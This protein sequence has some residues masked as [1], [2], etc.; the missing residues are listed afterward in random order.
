MRSPEP[1]SRDAG[2]TLVEA[3][4]VFVVLGILTAWAAPRFDVAVEQTRVDQAAAALRSIWLGQR[5]HWLEHQTFA[6]TLDELVE[7]RFLDGPMAAQTAP[8][9][10]AITDADAE[11]FG[12]TAERT[13]S[14]EWTGT[15]AIDERGA[16]TGETHG[17]GG[18]I[19]SPAQ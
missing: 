8:F 9:V 19:V 17:G 18:Q 1:H 3:M 12:A 2:F 7:E 5:M 14:T 10:L 11:A 4:L 15:V 6:A 13:D 16:I